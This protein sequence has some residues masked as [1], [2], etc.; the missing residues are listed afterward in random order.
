MSQAR[1]AAM[2]WSTDNDTVGRA[3]EILGERW[4]VVVLREIFNGIRRFDQIREHAGVPRQ[5]LT[6]RLAMLCEVGLLTRRP[7]Q[8]PG[9]RTRHE[10]RLT[11]MGFDVFP[12]VVAVRQ[13]GDRYLADADGP[14]VVSQHRDCGA[15]VGV[16]LA[17]AAGHHVDSPRDVV[18]RPGPGARAVTRTGDG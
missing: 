17:C 12:I 10:Y 2:D 7:Y 9:E 1:P 16:H 15:E 6:N 13:W 11:A 8:Q 14:P 5:V 4:T 18:F 3:M